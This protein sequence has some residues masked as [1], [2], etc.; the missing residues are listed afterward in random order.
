MNDAYWNR[1]SKVM[2]YLQLDKIIDLIF[3][4]LPELSEEMKKIITALLRSRG[5]L[6][7]WW[8]SI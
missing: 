1:Y 5:D 8:V 4:D 2:H 3:E 6:F 7:S